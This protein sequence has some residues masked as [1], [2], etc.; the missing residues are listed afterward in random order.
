MN[1]P[2]SLSPNP[3]LGLAI[4][5]GA[6][7]GF[8]VGAVTHN[9]IACAIVGAAIGV[10]VATATYMALVNEGGSLPWS[11]IVILLLLGGAITWTLVAAFSTTGRLVSAAVALVL[12]APT[13][14]WFINRRRLAPPRP[15]APPASPK[16]LTATAPA[17]ALQPPA[18][19]DPGLAGALPPAHAWALPEPPPRPPAA[20]A[21]RPGVEPL[22]VAALLIMGAL[23]AYVLLGAAGP[24]RII[25]TLLFT[26]LVPGWAIVSN[27]PA[28]AARGRLAPTVALSL[29][30]TLGGATISVWTHRWDPTV[31][32]YVEAGL[33]SA[34]IASGIIRRRDPSPPP[35]AG[36]A[37]R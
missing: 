15:P 16:A 30:V 32:F 11:Q 17:P 25:L 34:G 22:D 36:R 12:Y 18:S 10:F 37:G 31:L 4:P 29:A 13:G 2:P 9:V 6:G 14:V 1:R 35:A 28:I 20:A 19:P 33:S 8:I 7:I 24:P 23:L 26:I 21:A 3:T 5:L 27:L